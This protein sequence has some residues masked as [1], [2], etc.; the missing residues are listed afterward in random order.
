[1]EED[2]M[3]VDYITFDDL[4]NGKEDCAVPSNEQDEDM[5]LLYP[6]DYSCYFIPDEDE[7]FHSKEDVKAVSYCNKQWLDKHKEKFVAAWTCQVKHCNNQ[8]TRTVE[9]S[10]KRLKG[11]LLTTKGNLVTVWKAIHSMF[12]GD[13]TRIERDFQESLIRS[14]THYPN[15]PFLKKIVYNVS[16]YVINQ[17]LEDMKF[18]LTLA[19]R[20]VVVYAR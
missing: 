14:R 8:A 20:M 12:E 2:E 16:W 7:K 6:E 3:L 17:M 5:G 15:Y 11:E 4:S 1:M 13:R 9:S 18:G 10:H 19:G